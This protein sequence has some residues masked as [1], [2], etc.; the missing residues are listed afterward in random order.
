MGE[1]QGL[2]AANLAAGEDEG[3]L[4]MT[5]TIDRRTALALCGAALAAPSMPWAVERAAAAG[6]LFRDAIVIDGNLVASMFDDSGNVDAATAASVRGC[7]LTVMKQTLG[8]SGGDFKAA[9]E[10]IDEMDRNI[11][12]NPGQVCKILNVG[13]IAAAKRS[14]RLGVIYSFEAGSMHEGR[15]DRIDHF[16]GRGVRVMGLSYNLRSPFG[17][18]A[19]Q[20]RQRADAARPRSR[21]SDEHPWRHRGSEPLG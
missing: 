12:R 20:G 13:D 2:A 5:R 16:R 18:N 21:P 9:S 15:I 17:G 19:G 3:W 8:G 14:R 4:E 7:G 11:A 10:D 1:R 6:R